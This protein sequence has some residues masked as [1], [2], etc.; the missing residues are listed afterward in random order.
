MFRSATDAASA[1]IDY[2][3]GNIDDGVV[4]SPSNRGPE[5]TPLYSP[6]PLK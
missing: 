3:K 4:D 1:A 2:S 6:L 5:R